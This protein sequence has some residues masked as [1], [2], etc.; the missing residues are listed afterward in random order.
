M[1]VPNAPQRADDRAA[2]SQDGPGRDVRGASN[3]WVCSRSSGSFGAARSGR[4]ISLQVRPEFAASGRTGRSRRGKAWPQFDG[5]LSHGSPTLKLAPAVEVGVGLLMDSVSPAGRHDWL[6]TQHSGSPKFEVCFR[7]GATGRVQA[8]DVSSRRKLTFDPGSAGRQ[9]HPGAALDPP[10]EGRWD[11][12]RPPG[13][14]TAASADERWRS[15][16]N[17]LHCLDVAALR[18]PD[19]KGPA[20]ASG[21]EAP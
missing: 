18:Q 16:P 7:L 8:A 14:M 15:T 6:L 9:L 17:R 19:C 4:C 2:T 13:A 3:G 5:P 1:G 21:N 10:H 20:L 11:A 12:R